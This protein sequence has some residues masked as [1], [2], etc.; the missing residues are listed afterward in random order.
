MAP[1]LCYKKG[2]KLV[3]LLRGNW[4]Q[5]FVSKLMQSPIDLCT[6]VLFP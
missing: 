1:V 3:K 5:N 4:D 6:W 2:G